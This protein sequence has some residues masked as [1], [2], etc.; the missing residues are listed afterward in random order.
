MAAPRSNPVGFYNVN[1][2]M[3]GIIKTIKGL[4]GKHK[5]D[6]LDKSFYAGLHNHL[7]K[8]PLETQKHSTI[9]GAQKTLV[10]IKTSLGEVDQYIPAV[11]ECKMIN[12]NSGA[13]IYSLSIRHT[14]G[15]L[16]TL[17]FPDPI[18]I[19]LSAVKKGSAFLPDTQTILTVNA[20]AGIA[21][22]ESF[23]SLKEAVKDLF[24]EVDDDTVKGILTSSTISPQDEDTINGLKSEKYS[25]LLVLHK[26][27]NLFQGTANIDYDTF[28]G[29]VKDLL[30]TIKQNAADK[31]FFHFLGF[32][33]KVELKAGEILKQ[34]FRARNTQEARPSSYRG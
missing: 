6:F 27:I 26:K 9:D 20:K 34:H 11:L 30:E 8:S 22:L 14:D 17:F 12:D 13:E 15:S 24:K 29:E 3:F 33:S 1:L 5:K 16:S 10:G 18:T 19:T 25:N 32:Q 21:S 2:H 23:L 28:K 31:K 7:E 4:D